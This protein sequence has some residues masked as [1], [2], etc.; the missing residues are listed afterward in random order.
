MAKYKLYEQSRKDDGE[1]TECIRA[2][3]GWPGRASE[4][5]IKIFK[6]L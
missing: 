2:F 6:S 3:T 1:G 4:G 5:G